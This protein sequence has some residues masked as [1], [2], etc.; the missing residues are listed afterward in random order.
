[1]IAR[2]IEA[3]RELLGGVTPTAEEIADILWLAGKLE[4]AKSARRSAEASSPSEIAPADKPPHPETKDA[5]TPPDESVAPSEANSTAHPKQTTRLHPRY[6]QV[7]D[8]VESDI[9]GRVLYVQGGRALPGAMQIANA[10]R[11]FNHKIPSRREFIFDEEATVNYIAD[12]GIW[13]AVMRPS[14][15]RW[16]ELAIIVDGAAASMEIW[17]ETVSELILLLERQGAFRDVRTWFFINDD[18]RTWLQST[19]A[20]RADEL[21]KRSPSELIDP[22]GER[23]FLV[24]SD[25]VSQGWYNGVV[26]QMLIRWGHNAPLAILQVLPQGLW[27]Q[28]A[29][30]P[31]IL[32]LSAPARGVPNYQLRQRARHPALEPAS[33]EELPIPVITMEPRAIERW[34]AFVSGMPGAWVPGTLLPDR[35]SEQDDSRDAPLPAS[36]P[37][38][39]TAR[40]EQLV[41]RFRANAT[42]TAQ[43]LASY[44]AAAPIPHLDLPVMRL[45]QQEMLPES[46]QVHLAEVLIGPLLKS[47][48]LASFSDSDNGVVYEFEDGVR[49][50]LINTVP[51]SRTSEIVNRI[52]EF[53]G[54]RTGTARE[55]PAII[56]DASSPEAVLISKGS[57]ALAVISDSVLRRISWPY[58]PISNGTLHDAKFPLLSLKDINDPILL[59]KRVLNARDAVSEYI[60][61]Q[62]SPAL[63]Q[64][65]RDLDQSGSLNDNVRNFLLNELNRV[66]HRPDLYSEARFEHVKLRP[67]VRNLIRW[68]TSAQSWVR[69]NRLLLECAYPEALVAS[70]QINCLAENTSHSEALESLRGEF[71]HEYRY[72]V[73]YEKLEATSLDRKSDNVLMNGVPYYDVILQNS[74]KLST[75]MLNNW[76]HP[77]SY[78]R[79]LAPEADFSFEADIIPKIWKEI[80]FFPV[81]KNSEPEPI[82]YPVTAATM[83][84]VYNRKLFEDVRHKAAYRSEYSEDLIPP[85]TWEQFRRIARYFTMPDEATFGVVLQGRDN[86]LHFEWCNLAYNWGGGVM[87]KRYGW[88]GD[89]DTP[90]LIDSPETVAAT[91]YYVSLKPYNYGDF[92]STGQVEQQELMRTKKI[93]MAIMWSDSFYPLLQN[94]DA[95][96]FGFAPLPGSLSVI[97]GTT[98]FVSRYSRHPKESMQYILRMM[99]TETQVEL[100]KRG[101]ISAL[102]SVYYNSE[103]VKLPYTRAVLESLKRGVRMLDTSKESADIMTATTA[104]IRRIWDAKVSAEKGLVEARRD[105]EEALQRAY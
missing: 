88:E 85:A 40:A 32:R 81:I 100:A 44:F 93:A 99:K 4:G 67:E 39:I 84:L 66:L 18:K 83:L 58:E 5:A 38:D 26:K 61:Q 103:V 64:R 10:L 7:T 15:A 76:V 34:A 98:Y 17:E 95:E 96:N 25:C 35:M 21:Q 51:R 55:F 87:K 52:S 78:L 20:P 6:S 49:D 2:F 8:S 30:G 22:T 72:L 33:K 24:V 45:I 62:L 77:L 75:Y 14:Q 91:K 9:T 97:A 89:A 59:A 92:F 37:Q 104:A 16:P 70:I 27:R 41:G 101:L 79:S 94:R 105:I 50:L 1:M 60:R 56:E 63:K 28:T 69:I 73:D 82:G 29:L 23:L 57:E 13:H 47:N 74:Y 31:S 36:L 48:H 65:L 53:L 71:E 11:Y 90:I 42:P 54:R 43:R 102:G 80:G 86:F 3:V 46:G 68:Q 12:S 19:K